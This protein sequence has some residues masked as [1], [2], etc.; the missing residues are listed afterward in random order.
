MLKAFPNQPERRS[1]RLQR[2]RAQG[3]RPQRGMHRGLSQGC[4]AAAEL[5]DAYWSLA[6]LKTY[7]FTEVE[8]DAMRQQV[9]RP[10]HERRESCAVLLRA[11]QGA[12]RRQALRRNRSSSIA[13]ATRSCTGSRTTIP[14]RRAVGQVR[15]AKAMFTREFFAERAGLGSQSRDLDLHRRP[16]ALGYNVDR[17]DSGQPLADRRHDRA[18]RRCPISPAVW[19]AS[20]SPQTSR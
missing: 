8:I 11:R 18:A 1:A 2:P 5:G 7:R 20:S 19:A 6:N 3:A 12:R 9:G 13:A 15:R 10:G 17:T 4:I 16:A 14:M